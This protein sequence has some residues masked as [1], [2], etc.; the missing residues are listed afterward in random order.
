MNEFIDKLTRRKF[1]LVAPV[2]LALFLSAGVAVARAQDENAD[3]G[4]RERGARRE[5][6]ARRRGANGGGGL[7]RV[8]NLT[9]EQRAQIRAIRRETEPQG[10]SF[11]ARLREARRAL[12][13]A[14]HSASPDES[15]IE[16]RVREVGAAQT[17]VVRLRSL[18][19]L[20]IRRILSPEQL[21]A[22]RRLQRQ[23]RTRRERMNRRSLQQDETPGDAPAGFKNSMQR[24][25]QEQQQQQQR[26]LTDERNAPRQQR[27]PAADPPRDR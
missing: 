11:T 17:A 19:E 27:R 24:R 22:F 16:E 9:P 25:S 6:E 13:E 12:D 1:A 4:G 8:L 23:T 5:L 10:R 18:T 7:L 14:I 15:V 26:R 20:R 21:D 3:A 2:M